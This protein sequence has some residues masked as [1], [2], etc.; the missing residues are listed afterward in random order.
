MS[1]DKFLIEQAPD[2]FMN[3]MLIWM[4]EHMG[5]FNWLFSAWGHRITWASRAHVDQVGHGPFDEE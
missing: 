4:T 2:W 3:M 5:D 1:E